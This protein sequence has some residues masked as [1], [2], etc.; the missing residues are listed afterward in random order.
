MDDG[1]N[2]GIT[3]LVHKCEGCALVGHCEGELAL[4]DQAD[5]FNFGGIIDIIEEDGLAEHAG[6]FG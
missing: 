1:L 3:F 2:D 4:I 5:L 6:P